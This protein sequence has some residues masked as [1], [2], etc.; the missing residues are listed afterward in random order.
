[1]HPHTDSGRLAIQRMETSAIDTSSS[2]SSSSSFSHRRT[3]SRTGHRLDYILPQSQRFVND[4]IYTRVI[5]ARR[6]E[7]GKSEGRR[8]PPPVLY[9]GECR[10][11]EPRNE[12]ERGARE[13]SRRNKKIREEGKKKRE[14][15]EKRSGD[16][17]YDDIRNDYEHYG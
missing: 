4:A 9:N 17:R 14:T 1:M 6:A 8:L 5:D 10:E 16:R 2:S 15:D 7:E 3:D 11:G 12:E 13:G